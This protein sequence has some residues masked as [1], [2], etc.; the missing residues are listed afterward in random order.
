MIRDQLSIRAP[1]LFDEVAGVK[2]VVGDVE[3]AVVVAHDVL[4]GR[5]GVPVTSRTYTTTTHSTDSEDIESAQLSSGVRGLKTTIGYL[6]P[7]L[8]QRRQS[9]FFGGQIY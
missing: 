4:P 1:T 7:L 8:Y 3:R 6:N 9:R 5:V 2:I